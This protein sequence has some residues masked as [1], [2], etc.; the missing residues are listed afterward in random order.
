[1]DI[2]VHVL[3]AAT[4]NKKAPQHVLGC[5]PAHSAYVGGSVFCSWTELVLVRT[6]C[7]VVGAAGACAGAALVGVVKPGAIKADAGRAK[8]ARG[9]VSALGAHDFGVSAHGVFNFKRGSA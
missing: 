4:N 8:H 1:M 2:F 6:V 3:C 9:L 5:I 7:A